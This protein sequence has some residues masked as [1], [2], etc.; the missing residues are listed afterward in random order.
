MVEED[1]AEVEGYPNYAV[2]N[3][4]EVHNIK[5]GR[6]VRQRP[7]EQGFL[8]VE[9]S[10]RGI[11]KQFYVHQLVAQHFLE[12]WAPGMH[13]RHKDRNRNNNAADNLIMRNGRIAEEYI[14]Q[15]RGRPPRG[16][17]VEIVETGEVFLSARDCA[18]YIGGDYSSIYRCIRQ[19][20]SVHKGYHF[21]FYEE[22]NN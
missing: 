2:S 8:R 14:P 1:W 21:R 4:G 22:N 6:E 9:I 10:H 13:V 7:N 18:R 20:W 17:R 15:R 19:P 3:L 5:F 12:D 16:R 11:P